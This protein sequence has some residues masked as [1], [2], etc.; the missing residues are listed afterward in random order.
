MEPTAI[1]AVYSAGD[2]VPDFAQIGDVQDRK[3]SFFEYLVPVVRQE[4]ER[5]AR[6]RR[7]LDYIHDHIRF[8]REVSPEDLEWLRQTAAE[9][10]LAGFSP[11][12][13]AFW[14]T[15][16]RRVDVVP[17][18]LVLVQA[19]LESAWGTSR[20]AR[21]GN[22]FF[23]QWCF[24]PGCG[25]IPRSRADG[26]SHEVARFETVQHAVRS[27]LRNLNT[28]DSYRRFRD[29]RADLRRSEGA[30]DAAAMADGLHSYSQLGGDYVDRI[31]AMLRQNRELIGEAIRRQRP[32]TARG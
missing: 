17:V 14:D 11:R 31:R 8:R 12:K 24:E 22:N 23:G 13:P 9:A 16:G 30:L 15:L 1:P 32:Q 21:Q 2:A 28:G 5:L 7:R 20:F 27:Y 3:L 18:E 26:A 6:A 10:G 19:A 25:M 4:N 29:I